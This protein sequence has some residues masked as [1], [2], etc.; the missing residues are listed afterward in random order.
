MLIG[1]DD[2]ND[3]DAA[4]YY[5]SSMR[6][7]FEN[8]ADDGMDVRRVGNSFFLHLYDLWED[9][10]RQRIADE[11]GLEDKNHVESD[12]FA[13]LRNYRHGITHCGGIL[14]RRTKILHFYPKNN[15]INLS[16]NETNELFRMF[17]TELNRLGD[18]YYN[19]NPR[20]AYSRPIN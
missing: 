11:V 16:G 10:Y 4:T 20:F 9:K 14:R 1:D 15:A 8:M 18:V 6:E 19:V 2:P 3:P 12:F 17:V 5:Y 7:F 13:D